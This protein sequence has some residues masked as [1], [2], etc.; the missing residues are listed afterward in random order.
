MKMGKKEI[1]G[2]MNQLKDGDM[3]RFLLHPTF[4]GGM[5]IIRLNPNHPAKGQKKYEIKLGKDPASAE[6]S[7]PYWSADNPKDLA[8][9]VADRWGELVA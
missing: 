3:L 5:A 7:S 4:G 2:R 6:Q 1:V 8:G 9:W